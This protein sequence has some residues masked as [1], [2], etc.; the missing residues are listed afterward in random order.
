MQFQTSKGTNIVTDTKLGAGGE[1]VIYKMQGGN[2]AGKIYHNPTPAQE[3]KLQAMVANPPDDPMAGQKTISIAWPTEILYEENEKF[4]GFLMPFVP[5]MRPINEFYTPKVRVQKCPYFHYGYLVH[6]AFNL[7]SAINAVHGR[8]YVIGDVNESNV[9]VGDNALVVLVDTDSF[10]VKD[11]RDGMVYRCPV[12]KPEFTPPELQNKTFKDIDRSLEHD[13]FG[14]A[15]LFFQLMMEGVHP[16]SGIFQGIGETPPCEERISSGHFPYSSQQ[17]VPY[18]PSP[19]T[20]GWNVLSPNLQHLFL[21]CFEAGHKSPD[22]RPDAQIWKKQL[23]AAEQDLRKCATNDQHRYGSYLAACP[24]CERTSLRNGLDPFPDR[25]T[26]AQ[27]VAHIQQPQST[28]QAKQ[29]QA[30]PQPQPPKTARIPQPQAA[31]QAQHHPAAAQAQQAKTSKLPLQSKPVV[32]PQ[33]TQSTTVQ[34][35][36]TT[37]VAV[38]LKPQRVYVTDPKFYTKL[39]AKLAKSRAHSEKII[40]CCLL[41][42]FA[43]AYG[44]ISRAYKAKLAAVEEPRRQA[45]EE[46]RLEAQRALEEEMKRLAQ[47]QNQRKS[48]PVFSDPVE[49]ITPEEKAK[50]RAEEAKRQAQLQKEAAEKLAEWGK[51][52]KAA[53]EDGRYWIANSGVIHDTATNLEWYVALETSST[54]DKAKKCVEGLK[55]PNVDGGWQMPDREAL[56]SFAQQKASLSRLSPVL[57]TCR[58]VWARETEGMASAWMCDFANGTECRVDRN[59]PLPCAFAVR[60]GGQSQPTQERLAKLAEDAQKL[61]KLTR[62]LEETGSTSPQEKV[63]K[64]ASSD[65]RYWVSLEGVIFDTSTNLEWY[66][67]PDQN[68]SWEDAKSWA[69]GLAVDGGKWRMPSRE[70]LKTL[71]QKGRATRNMD[72]FF[73]TEGWILWAGE[74][75]DSDTAWCFALR[76]GKDGKLGR[77]SNYTC[78]AFAVRSGKQAME[79]LEAQ[80]QAQMQREAED[81]AELAERHRQEAET[82]KLAEQRK[83]DAEAARLA[84]QRR[85]DAE[86]A[87]LAEARAEVQR[88]AEVRRQAEREARFQRTQEVSADGRYWVLQDGVILD[89]RTSLEWYVSSDMGDTSWNDATAWTKNLAVDGGGWRMPTAGELKALYQAGK[90]RENRNRDPV[91]KVRGWWVWSGKAAGASSAWGLDFESG[92]SYSEPMTR[93]YSASAF[94]VRSAK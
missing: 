67:G 40:C 83:Q 58:W 32:Q 75:Q 70:E 88:Q 80:R 69:E 24:W 93:T 57:A 62:Q 27:A 3:R 77:T 54:W 41:L 72:A 35:Q 25:N 10:Q 73:K 1:A 42:V 81:A 90:G 7:A 85:Q 74:V 29:P 23:L 56:K 43:L 30:A 50:R 89:T 12:G 15:V 59:T 79:P 55:V 48:K 52:K 94:A 49:E 64:A 20:V 18:R 31:V 19:L 68:T 5:Q 44:V 28:A 65:G 36:T 87:R 71:Y 47:I 76:T 45:Q 8:G 66:L 82:A 6:T 84:E 26:L 4:A 34:P 22:K 11:S 46:K 86:A 39:Y 16:F 61:D 13:R 14:M 78:R 51:Q 9:L 17:S 60:R 53:T 63:K 92:N 91:F 21:Q 38:S 2:V 37:Q 33:Q